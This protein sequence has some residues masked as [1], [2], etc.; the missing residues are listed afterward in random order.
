MSLCSSVFQDIIQY[1]RKIKQGLNGNKICQVVTQGFS[2]K[3]YQSLSLGFVFSSTAFIFKGFFLW[4]SGLF[5]NVGLAGLGFIATYVLLNCFL[6]ELCAKFD[7]I[8]VP[9]ET[10]VTYAQNNSSETHNCCREQL[11]Y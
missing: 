10:A 4:Q 3:S 11:Q 5:S 2:F 1:I 8:Y 7:V 6:A 9:Q